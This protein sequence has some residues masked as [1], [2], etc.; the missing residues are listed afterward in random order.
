MAETWEDITGQDWQE[1]T[2]N[3]YKIR[4]MIRKKHSVVGRIVY[5]EGYLIDWKGTGK[6]ADFE[7]DTAVTPGELHKAKE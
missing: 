4:Y 1:T 6:Y 2:V 5:I 3:G 7:M